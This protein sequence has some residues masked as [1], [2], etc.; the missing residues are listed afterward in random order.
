MDGIVRSTTRRPCVAGFLA[1]AILCWVELQAGWSL[2]VRN[3]ETKNPEQRRPLTDVWGRALEVSGVVDIGE[4]IPPNEFWNRFIPPKNYPRPERPVNPWVESAV[5]SYFFGKIPLD[6]P[7]SSDR[8]LGLPRRG[9]LLG[10]TARP[11]LPLVVADDIPHF[12]IL[13]D[14]GEFSSTYYPRR[15]GDWILDGFGPAFILTG[16]ERYLR[17]IADFADFLLYSQYQEDG[18]NRFVQ[19]FYPGDHEELKAGGPARSWR[20][21]YDYLFDWEWPD[22]YGYRWRLHEPDH[23]VCSLYVGAMI[24]A[25][26]LTGDKRYLRSAEEF[27]YNQ[28]PRYG[29]HTGIWKDRRYYWTEYNPSG[30][31]NPTRDATDNVNALV[32]GAAAIL[33]YE[34]NDQRLL[35]FARGLLWYCVRE[36]TTDG[37]WY[38]DGAE[39]PLNARRAESHDLVVIDQGMSAVGYLVKAGWP[40]G[41]LAG[42]FN[43]TIQWHRENTTFL[44]KSAFF[45]GWK[46]F[47]GEPKAGNSVVVVEYI[48]V[49]SPAVKEL[50]LDDPIFADLKAATAVRVGRLAPHGEGWKSDETG[51]LMF[52]PETPG[53]VAIPPGVGLGE[54]VRLEFTWPVRKAELALRPAIL[55]A[56]VA[57][58]G[59]M[60]KVCSTIPTGLRVNAENLPTFGAAV[61]LPDSTTVKRK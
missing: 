57:G 6:A 35:E 47:I 24:R 21:G 49:T 56:Q 14:H 3:Q 28:V 34:K 50:M 27:F 36:W 5:R 1:V 48:H 22:A 40:V 17:R 23:H 19:D 18:S 37:R 8:Y 54:I 41:E 26:H 30:P 33:G 2:P 53:P 12:P 59:A 46:A 55:K 31:G 60:S 7:G 4:Q 51:R 11:E 42:P 29:F 10:K 32:A 58:R 45:Q 44:E 43:E 52:N 15:M 16:D 39:N 13:R 9:G 20:G 61:H 25:W 38:Y